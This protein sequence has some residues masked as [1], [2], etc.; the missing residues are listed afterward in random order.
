MK[1]TQRRCVKHLLI[2]KINKK[3]KR[4][5]SSNI[6]LILQI[7]Y[8]KVEKKKNRSLDIDLDPKFRSMF[9]AFRDAK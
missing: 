3:N 7:N 5:M 1:I 8:W 6:F 9:L 2:R 4:Y